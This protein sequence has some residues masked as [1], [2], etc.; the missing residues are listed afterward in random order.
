MLEL[1]RN[2]G[3]QRRDSTIMGIQ[4]GVIFPLLVSLRAMFPLLVSQTPA[5]HVSPVSALYTPN[6]T[7]IVT[8]ADKLVMAAGLY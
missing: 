7:Q 5:L 4:L 8:S 3:V 6:L 2:I 1:T